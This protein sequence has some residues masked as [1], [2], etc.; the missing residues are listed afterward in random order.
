MEVSF[1][2]KWTE[3]ASL[4]LEENSESLSYP[5]LLTLKES[6]DFDGKEVKLLELRIFEVGDLGL[7]QKSATYFV[8]L[9]RPS[10]LEHF[11][12]SCEGIHHIH[13]IH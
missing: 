10:C 9:R 1:A 5:V 12:A 11:R 2:A 8:P 6:M 7:L 13:C 3:I 4:R